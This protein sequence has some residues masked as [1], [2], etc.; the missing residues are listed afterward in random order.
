MVRETICHLL[1][2]FFLL[3]FSFTT[4]WLLPT[5]FMLETPLDLDPFVHR[6]PKVELHLHLEGSVRTETLRELSRAKGRL[7]NETEDWISQRISSRFR[8]SGFKEFLSAFKWVTLLLE[9]PSDYAL[10]TSRLMEWLA[11]QN[12]KYAEIILSAGVLLWKKQSVPAVFEAAAQAACETGSRLGVRVNWIFDAVRQFGADHARAVLHWAA[13]FRTA[14][15]VAFGLGG[16]EKGGPADQFVSVCREARE[17]G[18]HVT[19]HAGE[20]AGPESICKSVELLR[21]ERI[22]HGLA[23]AQDEAVIGLLRDRRIPLEVCPS[24]NVCTGLLARLEDHPLPSFLRSGL[25]V[26]LNSD[27]PAMFGTSL[28]GE[29]VLAARTFA[30]DKADILRLSENGIRSA[31]LAESEQENLLAELHGAVTSDK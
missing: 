29:F 14:G 13:R 6:L 31:F 15:V 28:E 19:V 17:L 22:G 26:T 3:P 23:A 16:D 2:A 5:A 9:T 10:I 20:T 8:Y 30:L 12:V 27:D 21:A 18:L 7:R 4:C 11:V 25:V 1:L 24:S